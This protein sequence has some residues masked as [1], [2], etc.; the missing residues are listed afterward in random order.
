MG[1]RCRGSSVSVSTIWAW[2]SARHH[3]QPRDDGHKRSQTYQQSE[4]RLQNFHLGIHQLGLRLYPGSSPR[5]GDRYVSLRQGA[6]SI[7]W[8]SLRRPPAILPQTFFLLRGVIGRQRPFKRRLDNTIATI[9][10]LQELRRLTART[11]SRGG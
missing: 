11:E 4:N 5:N 10:H 8:L 1:T 3:Y 2:G 6:S 7:G 9:I